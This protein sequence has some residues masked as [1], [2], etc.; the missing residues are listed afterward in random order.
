[1]A[2]AKPATAEAPGRADGDWIGA[3][4]PLLL[5]FVVVIVLLLLTY[6]LFAAHGGG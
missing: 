4:G 2:G 5:V 3:L 1:M 6:A